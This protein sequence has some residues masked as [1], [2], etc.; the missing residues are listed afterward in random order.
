M[1]KAWLFYFGRTIDDQINTGWLFPVLIDVVIDFEFHDLAARTGQLHYVPILSLPEYL[2]EHVENDP[3]LLLLAL[4][5]ELVVEEGGNKNNLRLL[6]MECHN[7]AF[8]RLDE[9]LVIAQALGD[10]HELWR[11][12]L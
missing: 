8:R 4:H 2:A 1:G 10:F 3:V 7:L 11:W 12:D 6:P 5:A 9:G